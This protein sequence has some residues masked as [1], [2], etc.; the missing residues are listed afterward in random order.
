MNKLR[1]LLLGNFFIKA[2]SFLIAIVLWFFTMNINNPV[3]EKDVTVPLTFKNESLITDKGYVIVNKDQLLKTN[4]Q[5]KIKGTRNDMDSY[6]RYNDAVVANI[7]FSTIDLTNT[8]IIGQQ[9]SVPVHAYSNYPDTFSFVSAYPLTVILNI[10]VVETKTVPVYPDVTGTPKN[11]YVLQDNPILSKNTITI[12]GPKS[13]I[14]KVTK[15][16]LPLNIDNVDGDI[17]KSII[18]V[19]YNDKNEDV[20]SSIYSGLDEITITQHVAKATTV[21]LVK[22]SLVGS[23][24][25]G[26]SL[27]E[28]YTDIQKLEVLAD[29]S[30]PNLS[31]NPIVLDSINISD[32]RE[33][34]VIKEDITQKLAK[35]GLKAKSTKNVTVTT[36]IIIEED[37]SLTLNVPIERVEFSNVQYKYTATAGNDFENNVVTLS[38]TGPS[39]I[40]NKI[41]LDSF[42]FYCELPVN[43]TANQFFTTVTV[44]LPEGVK[45]N[46]VPI[47]DINLTNDEEEPVIE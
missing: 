34:E 14:D 41:D 16:M 19:V 24:P 47:L 21:E 42:D 45:L 10:D 25:A 13:V 31:F 1:E 40:L 43:P 7:D 18:P 46:E 37:S 12:T 20:S 39:E 26:Y 32:F 11:S 9:L 44:T 36:T 4:V 22:P 5:V 28:Y 8:A 38:V 6:R 17:D 2:I 15:A 33:N 29:E 23:L 3:V 27:I 35:Q 30:N